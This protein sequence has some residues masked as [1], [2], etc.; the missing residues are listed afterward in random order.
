MVG[1]STLHHECCLQGGIE[2]KRQEGK[3]QQILG[4]CHEWRC[5]MA[6]TGDICGTGCLAVG[7]PPP[8][9]RSWM[10]WLHVQSALLPRTSARARASGQ[11]C[12]QGGRRQ[13]RTPG[14]CSCLRT[15]RACSISKQHGTSGEAS[16]AGR[17]PNCWLHRSGWPR[18]PPGAL[19][20]YPAHGVIGRH[21]FGGQKTSVCSFAH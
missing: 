10:V 4:Q 17:A 21:T 12:A 7:W 20:I 15:L 14:T 6:L 8:L 11:R 13:I 19:S 9:P 2:H 3:T 16:L 1:G 5:S 18:W